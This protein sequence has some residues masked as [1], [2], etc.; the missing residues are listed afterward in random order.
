MIVRFLP[1]PQWEDKL[2]SL[3]ATPLQGLGKLNT[4]EWWKVAGGF[5]FTV[6][7]E[8]DGTCDYWALQKICQRLGDKTFPPLN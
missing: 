4:S 7:V 3:G 2:K 6:P 8:P 5:P 1:R